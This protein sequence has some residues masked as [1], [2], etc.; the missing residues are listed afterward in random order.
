MPVEIQGQRN[1]WVIVQGAGL[2][3][4]NDIIHTMKLGDMPTNCLSCWQWPNN[5][6]VLLTSNVYVTIAVALMI[7][8][9]GQIWHNSLWCM[10][11]PIVNWQWLCEVNG[12]LHGLA[13]QTRLV[14]SKKQSALLFTHHQRSFVMLRANG[15]FHILQSRYFE[16]PSTS[17][18]SNRPVLSLEHQNILTKCCSDMRCS[19]VT[20]HVT[21][22]PHACS[23][24]SRTATTV[25]LQQHTLVSDLY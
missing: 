7:K 23:V 19:P 21:V 20:Y 11:I 13:G 22:I 2:K 15:H 4:A 3:Q 25:W 12:T 1:S 18:K 5:I 24:D 17:H 8:L 14:T 9:T 6:C 10:F 16:L